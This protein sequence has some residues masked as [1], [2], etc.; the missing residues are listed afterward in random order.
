MPD[1][2]RLGAPLLLILYALAVYGIFLGLEFLV[3]QQR[4]PLSYYTRWWRFTGG[5]LRF[6]ALFPAVALSA[7]SAHFAFGHWDVEGRERFSPRFLES[8]TSP[9]V[10]ALIAAVGYGALSLLVQ[11]ACLDYRSRVAIDASLFKTSAE[12]A[13]QAVKEKD[14]LEAGRY[15]TVCERIWPG[16][17]TT[18]ADRTAIQI[19]LQASAEATK[20]GPGPSGG[21]D[22][23]APAA[24]LPGVVRSISSTEAV[25][26]AQQALSQGRYFD[27]HWLASLAEKLS[28][29]QAPEYTEAA[30]IASAAWNAIAKL[31]PKA[32]DL[33]AYAVYNL[34]REGYAAVVAEDWIKAYYIFE[35]LLG[36]SRSDPDVR[37]YY[38]LSAAG[39]R[40]V[41]FFI[42]EVGVKAGASEGPVLLSIPGPGGGRIV[43]RAE[44][45]HLFSDVAYG[46][47]LELVSF[48]ASGAEAFR[49]VSPFFKLAPL[50]D[51]TAGGAL[52][53]SLLLLALDRSDPNRRWAPK[54]S[55]APKSPSNRLVLGAPFGEL[56][57]A[58][59]ARGGL[60]VLTIPELWRGADRLG[61]YGFLPEA[62]RAEMMRRL[63]EPFSFLSLAIFILAIAWRTRAS[64]GTG[65]FGVLMLAPLPFAM[66]LAVQGYRVVSVTS[67]ALFSVL[68]PVE[69]SMAAV[70]AFQAFFL[71]LAF[72]FLAGQRG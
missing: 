52:R 44:G 11:P 1:R 51:P 19:G 33:E 21:P 54:W 16:S 60:R 46:E 30:R 6:I 24:L 62:F 64:R 27:A 59:R 34:K 10:A 42:D 22:A 20:G 23:A 40:T 8:M 63:V 18:A 45:L 14:W 3:P 36:R 9:V 69:L 25:V 66:D 65:V 68:L 29:P 53:T 31:E 7:L 71:L 5:T 26:Q 48:D 15:M 56:S 43:F 12:R 58:V 28:N 2:R 50:T 35:S 32:S 55:P 13:A 39:A 67:A 49:I 70:L 17:P 57:L 38:D 4:E 61:S 37:R 72:V 41:A 47:G